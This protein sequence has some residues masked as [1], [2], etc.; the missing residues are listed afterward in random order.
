MTPSL[1]ALALCLLLF[2][3]A[4]RP[5]ACQAPEHHQFDFWI[6]EWVVEDAKGQRLGTS[7][8]ERIES[9]CGIQENWTDRSGLTGRSINVYQPVNK[10]WTQLWAASWGATLLL[11]GQYENEQMVLTGD[12]LGRDGAPE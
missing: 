4:P 10:T 11:V 2:Q 3:T 5:A 8:V 12:V 1:S 6:G 9:G 7:R